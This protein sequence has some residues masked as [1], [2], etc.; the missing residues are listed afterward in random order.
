MQ[1]EIR[2]N[3]GF[4]SAFKNRIAKMEVWANSRLDGE[5]V[6]NNCASNY[7]SLRLE[8]NIT[9]L[10]LHEGCSCHWQKEQRK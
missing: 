8:R 1:C 7:D 3:P 10:W 4:V 9:R 5:N 6:E 2:R